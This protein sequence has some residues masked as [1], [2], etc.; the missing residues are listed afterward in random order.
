LAR[1]LFP[2]PILLASPVPLHVLPQRPTRTR[3]RTDCCTRTLQ[4]RRHVFPFPRRVQHVADFCYPPKMTLRH[5]VQIAFYERTDRH[6]VERCFTTK[7]RKAT[8]CISVRHASSTP[9]IFPKPSPPSSPKFLLKTFH[10]FAQPSPPVTGEV[11]ALSADG[12]NSLLILPAI[13]YCPGIAFYITVPPFVSIPS[14]S[15][16]GAWSLLRVEL[17]PLV[18][19]VCMQRIYFQEANVVR[20]SSSR[21][22]A[23]GGTP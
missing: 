5:M 12:S 4:T 6:S 16:L 7:A 14:N 15:S 19:T 20:S 17:T 21:R 22:S 18:I 11:A 2:P 3:S 23:F 8:S 10:E 1:V 9:N 13:F